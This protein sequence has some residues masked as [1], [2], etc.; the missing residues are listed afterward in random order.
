MTQTPDELLEAV[1]QLTQDRTVVSWLGP[2]EHELIPCLGYH[3]PYAVDRCHD[4]DCAR[5]VCKLCHLPEDQYQEAAEFHRQVHPP[6]LTLLIN[7]TGKGQPARSSDTRIPIDADALELWGQVR[8]LVKLW[9]RQLDATFDPDDLL[10]SVRHWYLAHTNAHRSKRISDVTDLDVTRMVQGWV[11]MIEAK[12][13]PPEKR[14]WKEACPAFVPVRNVDGDQIG[15][16]RC[17]ARRVVVDGEERFAITLNVTAMKAEC[18]RCHHVWVGEV[19][20]MQLRYETN[21]WNLEKDEDEA[22]RQAALD[23]LAY[24][25]TPTKTVDENAPE[26]A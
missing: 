4:I 14:E 12:F 25:D 18:A 11:R 9:C 22:K 23:A 13:D 24:P 26:V 6:L 2:H 10:L 8:D 19:G 20:I 17:G 3:D 16:R 7:G 21:L 15:T 1:D 5:S